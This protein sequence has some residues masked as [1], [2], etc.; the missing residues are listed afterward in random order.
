[1]IRIHCAV[2]Y[3]TVII[4][5]AN[6][7]SIQDQLADQSN[8]GLTKCIRLLSRFVAPKRILLIP[9]ITASNLSTIGINSST[10]TSLLIAFADFLFFSSP[11][12]LLDSQRST[13]YLAF[14][15][16][17]RECQA[18]CFGVLRSVLAFL[19]GVQSLAFLRGVL[20]FVGFPRRSIVPFRS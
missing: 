15:N 18:L 11:A 7:V 3:L 16:A 14:R 19:H 6:A 2:L 20:A 1:M 5:S 17:T 4:D 8:V 10:N 13:T 12:S 9:S